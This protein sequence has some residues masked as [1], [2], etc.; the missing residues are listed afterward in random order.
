MC[1]HA[2][3]VVDLNRDEDYAIQLVSTNK[4]ELSSMDVLIQNVWQ[5]KM[6]NGAFRYKLQHPAV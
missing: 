6:R 1:S 5:E 3:N 4:E 2:S